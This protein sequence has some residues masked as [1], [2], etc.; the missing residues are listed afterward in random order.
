[1]IIYSDI[2]SLKSLSVTLCD[3]RSYFSA[4][5]GERL[6]FSS[7]LHLREQASVRVMCQM[8]R[9]S[10]CIGAI[11]VFAFACFLLPAAFLYTFWPVLVQHGGTVSTQGKAPSARVFDC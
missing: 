8:E 7:L 1:M 3:L 9:V 6:C 10:V 11:C 4:E 2:F 5:D